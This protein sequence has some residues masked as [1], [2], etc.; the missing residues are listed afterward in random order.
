M[1]QKYTQ[2]TLSKPGIKHRFISA[3]VSVLLV[4]GAGVTHSLEVEKASVLELAD[5][6]ELKLFFD[7]DLPDNVRSFT[8]GASPRVHVIDFPSGLVNKSLPILRDQ[9]A[10]VPGLKLIHEAS[11]SRIQFALEQDKELHLARSGKVM[12]FRFGGA[13]FVEPSAPAGLGNTARQSTQVA[14]KAGRTDF[15]QGIL[16]DSSTRAVLSGIRVD[17]R[18][19]SEVLVMSLSGVDFTPEATLTGNRLS[20]SLAEVGAGVDP[21]IYPPTRTI[22]PQCGH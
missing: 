11:G 17:S 19:E 14:M 6:T 9:A 18:P 5:R 3:A 13:P 8:L 7:Q 22:F 2:L 21:D 16:S 12:F 10:K 1:N 15:Q 4:S 20:I